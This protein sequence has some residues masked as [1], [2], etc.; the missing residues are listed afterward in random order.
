MFVI[1]VA[2]AVGAAL[3]A[4]ATVASPSSARLDVH[5]LRFSA[6]STAYLAGV[7]LYLAISLRRNKYWAY[8]GML[9]TLILSAM[10]GIVTAAAFTSGGLA[11]RIAGGTLALISFLALRLY[12]RPA[13]LAA[14]PFQSDR[15]QTAP[16][17]WI[18]LIAAYH[19]LIAGSMFLEA[20]NP[21]PS[22][23]FGLRV[24]GVW[25]LLYAL[26]S[27]SVCLYIGFD[28]YAM[29]RGGY[30]AALAFAIWSTAIVVFS[31][32]RPGQPVPIQLR[33]AFVAIGSATGVF[34][35]YQLLRSRREFS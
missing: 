3:T 20:L 32:I 4:V 30:R 16:T 31:M 23:L 1:G 13:V 35:L 7:A 10:V 22:R 15:L 11:G 9:C 2:L 33:V 14:F 5:T 25:L 28:L 19:L 18:R 6:L 17:L 12:V 8:D 34:I 27:G 24:H 21:S 29:R 26:V